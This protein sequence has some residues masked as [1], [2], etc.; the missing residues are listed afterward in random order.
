MLTVFNGADL[1]YVGLP[2]VT[3]FGLSPPGDAIECDWF[4]DRFTPRWRKSMRRDSDF[5]IA[6]TNGDE[7]SVIGGD[8]IIR[9]WDN[10]SGDWIDEEY[11]Y[12]QWSQKLISDGLEWLAAY[13]EAEGPASDDGIQ[14]EPPGEASG[15]PAGGSNQESDFRA[16]QNDLGNLKV[17]DWV[18][19]GAPGIWKIYRILTCKR[20]AIGTCCE[21]E[22][23]LVFAKRFLS[24]SL[25][26]SFGAECWDPSL[27]HKLDSGDQKQLAEFI[28]ANGRQHELFERYEPK[29]IDSIYNARI[30]IPE[31]RSAAEVAALFDSSQLI[32]E[33]DI[34][35]S[36]KEL[37]FDTE[38]FPCWT[39]QFTSEDHQCVDNYLV[40]KFQRVIES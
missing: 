13:E 35:Q 18:R 10:Q 39:I 22:R 5:V 7:I 21:D 2:S 8:S 17:G 14:C 12:E 31:D 4:I 38:D 32:R 23:T 20:A 26:K 11:D 1:F 15:S 30:R 34:C 28:E 36:L 24:K 6:I 16:G 25:K 33:T 3:I 27:V 19:V 37:G 9:V 40:Y 29:P